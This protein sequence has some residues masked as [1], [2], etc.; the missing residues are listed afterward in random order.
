[1]PADI[2][3]MQDAGGIEEMLSSEDLK[4]S[5]TQLQDVS[6]RRLSLVRK[7]CERYGC[8]GLS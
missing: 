7:S 8:I 3:E 2:K 1:M 6:P 4:K 5:P